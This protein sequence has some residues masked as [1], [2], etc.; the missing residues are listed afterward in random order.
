M[1]SESGYLR[2]GAGGAVQL[3]VAQVTGIA[4]ASSG[5]YDAATR[6]LTLRSTSLGN[7]EKVQEVERQYALSEDAGTLSV[8]VSMRTATQALQPH[9][10]ATLRRV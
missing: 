1:H 10:R 8:V 7:A 3:A 4:E 6:T 9:L 5:S 2:C